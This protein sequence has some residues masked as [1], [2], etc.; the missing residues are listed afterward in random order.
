MHFSRIF[1]SSAHCASSPDGSLIATLFTDSISIRSIETLETIHRIKLPAKLGPAN[2]L[3]WSPSSRRVLASYADQIHVYSA[4]EPGYHAVVRNP[5]SPNFRPTFVQFGT[6]DDEIIMFSSFGLKFSIFHLTT[7]KTIEINSPKFH[8]PASAPRGFA[9]R[10]SGHLALLTRLAGKDIVSIHHHA[11]REVQRSWHPD[12]IDAQGLA[13]TPNG[14]WLVIWESAAQGHKILFYTPDGHLFRTWAGPSAFE[15]DDKHV[16]LGA[17]VKVCQISPDGARIA[18]CDHTRNVSVLDINATSTSMRLEHPTAII[19]KDTLQVW[20]EQIGVA[21][22]GFAHSFVKASQSVSA[23]GR[24]GG[25]GVETVDFAEQLPDSR[26]FGK[27]QLSWLDWTGE[28]A[29]L[30]LGDAKHHLMVSLA[31]GED[32][33]APWQDAQRNDLTMTT[34]KDDTQLEPAALDDFDED[35]SGLD[36]SEV[37]D[38]FSF[39]KM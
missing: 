20:Q 38:T 24:A 28:S 1:K 14:H 30:L 3:L 6:S 35:L 36:M 23:P 25:G 32:P 12:T 8:Q 10:P 39:K 18:V 15:T 19:P 27:P 4:L 17:G 16:E 37:D 31:D 13:W 5:A 34:G 29:I 9:I 21:P 26:V 11:T 2:A 7:S 22:S 33:A